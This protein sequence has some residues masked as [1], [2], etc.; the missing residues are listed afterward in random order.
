MAH[1]LTNAC[2]PLPLNFS[3][4]LDFYKHDSKARRLFTAR[5]YMVWHRD[6]KTLKI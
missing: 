2:L 6:E 3:A 5:R 1:G 4:D